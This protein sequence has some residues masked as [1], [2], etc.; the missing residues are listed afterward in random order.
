MK[1]WL[2]IAIVFIMFFCF[3]AVIGIETVSAKTNPEPGGPST[4]SGVTEGIADGLWTAGVESVVD[5]SLNPAPY[6][7]IQLLSK[8]TS[9]TEPGKVC[10]PFRGGQFHWVAEIRQ[11]VDGKWVKVPTTVEKLYGV[12]SGLMA[13]IQAPAAGIYALFGYYTG[14]YE[15]PAP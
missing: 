9:I 15:Y 12:E 2:S 7:W 1:H 4:G 3:F 13:C 14:P 8:Q 6:T 11:L 5:L 10:H